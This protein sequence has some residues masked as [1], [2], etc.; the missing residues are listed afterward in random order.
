MK[1]VNCNKIV[2]RT[3]EGL[4]DECYT[5]KIPRMFRSL[6]VIGLINIITGSAICILW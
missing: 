3:F 1:C 6:V 2:N 4:C 5:T